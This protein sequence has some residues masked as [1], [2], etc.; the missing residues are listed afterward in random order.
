MLFFDPILSVDVRIHT[1]FLDY[2]ELA[3]SRDNILY[4]RAVSGVQASQALDSAGRQY[5][6]EPQRLLARKLILR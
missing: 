5:N 6:R 4:V 1:N 3:L 2:S